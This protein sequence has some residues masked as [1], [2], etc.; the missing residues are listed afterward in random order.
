[1]FKVGNKVRYTSNSWEDCNNNPLWGGSQ[2]QVVGTI[3]EINDWIRVNWDNGESNAYRKEDL[4]SVQDIIKTPYYTISSDWAGQTSFIVN[5]KDIINGCD[6][7]TNNTKPMN[8]LNSMMKRLLD[9]DTKTLIKSGFINGDLQLTQE[10][11]E[12]LSAILFEANKA[13][14]VNLAEEKIAEEKE[15]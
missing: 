9:K 7:I 13:E 15:K 1:M 10:G 14:L 11:Q 8:K 4:E 5:T 12:A 2:G 3:Y 6:T